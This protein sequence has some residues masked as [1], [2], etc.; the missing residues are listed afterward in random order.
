MS[1]ERTKDDIGRISRINR[2]LFA[3]LCAFLI[4]GAAVIVWST[5]P[6]T[7]EDWNERGESLARRS[8]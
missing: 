3:A 7:A 1:A 4:L 6:R 2:A 8:K 5:L